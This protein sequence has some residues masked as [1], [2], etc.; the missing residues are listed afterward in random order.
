MRRLFLLNILLLFFSFSYSQRVTSG[1]IN[2]FID[3]T[4]VKVVVDY[5]NAI[6]DKL[7]YENRCDL[8]E[9]WVKGEKEVTARFLKVLIGELYRHQIKVTKKAEVSFVFH[10]TQID[11]DGESYA[12]AEIIDEN[13]NSLVAINKFHGEGGKFGSLSNL[14]GDGME[15]LAKSVGRYL[16]LQR[17]LHRSWRKKGKKEKT[18]SDWKQKWQEK[19]NKKKSEEN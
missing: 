13:V 11:D 12:N 9:G 5:S 1:D 6:I 4:E 15:R 2:C 10:V 18:D 16:D 8:D 14:A 17:N 7:D 3:I 19:N